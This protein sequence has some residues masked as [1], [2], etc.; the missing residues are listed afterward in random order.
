MRP[1]RQEQNWRGQKF[2]PVLFLR[3]GDYST[4]TAVWIP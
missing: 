3:V 2:P 4:P 1:G